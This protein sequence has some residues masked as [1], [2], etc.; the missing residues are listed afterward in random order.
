MIEFSELDGID[1]GAKLILQCSTSR[2]M[3]YAQVDRNIYS[4]RHWAFTRDLRDK[5]FY[6]PVLFVPS[7]IF[8]KLSRPVCPVPNFFSNSPDPENFRTVP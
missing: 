4:W 3:M 8:F 7:R 1:F 6:C 2:Y 5:L